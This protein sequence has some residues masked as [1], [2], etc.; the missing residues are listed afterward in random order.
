LSFTVTAA[1]SML[2]IIVAAAGIKEEVTPSDA[3]VK[4]GSLTGGYRCHA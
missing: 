1:A 4:S 2:G 3:P